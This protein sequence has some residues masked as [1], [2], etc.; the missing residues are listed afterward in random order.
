MQ[1]SKGSWNEGKNEKTV[2]IGRVK[3]YFVKN[4]DDY[5]R[6]LVALNHV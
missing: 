6:V 3:S 4:K 1:L 2:I 5:K